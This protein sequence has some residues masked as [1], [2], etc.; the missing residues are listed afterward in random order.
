[1]VIGAEPAP[2]AEVS[3]NRSPPPP[4]AVSLRKT[5]ALR[6]RLALKLTIAPPPKSL[7]T[8][9][10][11]VRP[12]SVSLRIG[13]PAGRSWKNP[14]RC[15]KPPPLRVSLSA[16]GPLILASLPTT[17]IRPEVIVIV[18]PT[19][20]G[21]K[22]TVS[23]VAAA[24]TRARPDP[25]RA[26]ARCAARPTTTRPT[27]GSAAS[28][29]PENHRARSWSGQRGCGGGPGR[30]DEGERGVWWTRCSASTQAR[31]ACRRLGCPQA[32]L[33]AQDPGSRSTGQAKSGGRG[34]I[35]QIFAWVGPVYI[36]TNPDR[37]RPRR[38]RLDPNDRPSS[39]KS[40]PPPLTAS[41]PRSSKLRGPGPQRRFR[42][43]WRRE[44]RIASLESTIP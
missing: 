3:A 15:E 33:I 28:L 13:E 36:P 26:T 8:A 43:R 20:D 25:G 16:P 4:A 19:S 27:A 1:M 34:W 9:S 2:K 41:P 11:S 6:V 31:E 44:A 22:S 30:H 21:A 5:S 39:P 14:S 24:A 10:A 17:G 35:P 18:L 32:C 29:E 38:C 40:R 7:V 12:E 42:P 23:P 37:T